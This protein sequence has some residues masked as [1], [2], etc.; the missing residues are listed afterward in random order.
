[1]SM[2]SFSFFEIC[3]YKEIGCFPKRPI[4]IVPRSLRLE[5]Q[6]D[7]LGAE[8]FSSYVPEIESGFP[9]LLASSV[10]STLASTMLLFLKL[11]QFC[12]IFNK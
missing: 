12:G 3:Y 2:F 1:M 8:G 4:G 6:K 7:F 5:A 9:Y 10:K 11:G